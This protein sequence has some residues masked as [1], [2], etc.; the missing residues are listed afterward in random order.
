MLLIIFF[1]SLVFK[2]WSSDGSFYRYL[3]SNVI[4]SECLSPP[5]LCFFF[6]F[7]IV[8][9]NMTWPYYT[10]HLTFTCSTAHRQAIRTSSPNPF[11]VHPLLK[12]PHTY[13]QSAHKH[14]TPAI[15]SSCGLPGTKYVPLDAQIKTNGRPQRNKRTNNEVHSSHRVKDPL[16]KKSPFPGTTSTI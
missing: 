5:L 4:F 1:L 8:I 2:S 11:L 15:S 9:K 7:H 3:V 6:R 13:Q 12:H 10:S 14:H 16:T